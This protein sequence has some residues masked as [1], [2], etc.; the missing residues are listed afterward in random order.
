MRA[1]GGVNIAIMPQFILPIAV[2]AI[3]GKVEKVPRM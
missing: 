2:T 3:M 1:G